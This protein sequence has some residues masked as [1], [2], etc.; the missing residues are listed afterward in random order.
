[1]RF[2]SINLRA[3]SMRARTSLFKN[4]EYII[5]AADGLI[6]VVPRDGRG[7][8][9]VY[10]YEHLS[11]GAL[12]APET[13]D[14]ETAPTEPPIPIEST[15]A[16]QEPAPQTPQRVPLNINS[17]SSAIPFI[18]PMQSS[19]IAVPASQQ[20]RPAKHGKRR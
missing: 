8:T 16:E 14:I 15:Q 13:P 20:Y 17:P 1:M 12:L 3:P 19:P 4:S 18:V 9:L 10:S 2:E 7:P 5:E 6:T 11:E